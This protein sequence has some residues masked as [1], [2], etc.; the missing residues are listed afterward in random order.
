MRCPDY[1]YLIV[2]IIGNHIYIE[3]FDVFKGS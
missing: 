2:R 3:E 1:E